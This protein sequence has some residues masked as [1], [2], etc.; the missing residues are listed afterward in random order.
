MSDLVLYGDFNCPFSA[1]ASSRAAELER[2]G[3]ATVDWRAVEHDSG[4]PRHGAEVNGDLADMLRGELAQINDLLRPGEPRRSRLPVR[5][6]NTALATERF[7]GTAVEARLSVRQEIFAAHWE[8]AERIDDQ[9]VLDRLGAGPVD[10]TLA[11]KWRHGWLA[12]KNPIVPVLVLPDGY[13]SR[14]LGALSRLA[15]MLDG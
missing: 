5:Q 13:I 9:A 6:V 4:L 14:G 12:A 15:A 7:A 1:L 2:G 11:A 3:V 8:R 10:P